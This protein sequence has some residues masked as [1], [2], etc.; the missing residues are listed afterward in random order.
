MKK[1]VCVLATSLVLTTHSA[2]LDLL[3]LN[4]EVHLLRAGYE[5]KFPIKSLHR[6][7]RIGH[8]TYIFCD[9]VMMTVRLLNQDLYAIEPNP[10]ERRPLLTIALVEGKRRAA[11][12]LRAF[13][14]ALRGSHELRPGNSSDVWVE[15]IRRIGDHLVV[16]ISFGKLPVAVGVKTDKPIDAVATAREL[17]ARQFDAWVERI[18][19]EDETL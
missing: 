8:D 9:N 15:S 13:S 3:I 4:P 18:D 6:T 19:N 11:E 16:A 14:A 17:V 5:V 1:A 7:P 12:R 2:E 10:L